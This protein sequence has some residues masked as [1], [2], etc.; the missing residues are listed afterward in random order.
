M[1]Q[2]RGKYPNRNYPNL[3]N[4]AE[5]GEEAKKVFNDAQVLL[6]RII[7]EKLL[8]AKGIIGFYP[9]SGEAEDV[10]V[11]T[12]EDR[13]EVL[14]TFYGLRQQAENLD[15]TKPYKALGDFVAPKDSGVKDY[16]GLFAVSAGVPILP[17]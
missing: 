6:D 13:T 16:I 7:K 9:C 17:F 10:I 5:V 3:F 1:W 4:D 14:T 2:L 8:V 15:P 12:N 11:Y